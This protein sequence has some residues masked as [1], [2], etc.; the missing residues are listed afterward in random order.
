MTVVRAVALRGVLAGTQGFE[1]A[2][3]TH[4]RSR[5][6]DDC[7]DCQRDQGELTQDAGLAFVQKL[8]NQ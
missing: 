6:E 5:A 7:R 4:S 3:M 2:A 8:L 1:L